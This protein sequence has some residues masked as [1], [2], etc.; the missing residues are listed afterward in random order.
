MVAAVPLLASMRADPRI[1]E[2]LEHGGC[3]GA[4]IRLAARPVASALLPSRRRSQKA[5]SVSGSL[6][7]RVRE[8]LAA[9][10]GRCGRM[11][12]RRNPRESGGVLGDTEVL[13]NLRSCRPNSAAPA[14]WSRY[15][16]P[17]VSPT[18]WSPLPMRLG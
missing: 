7:D 18:S 8:R 16:A 4:A 2:R 13:S 9:E 12:C 17:T 1:A 3:G 10:S 5:G 6:I 15:C 11:W 14:S